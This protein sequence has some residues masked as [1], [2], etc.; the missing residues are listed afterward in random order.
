MIVS[1]PLVACG[2]RVPSKVAWKAVAFPSV[3][4]DEGASLE[5]VSV[6]QRCQI[7]KLR[8]IRALVRAPG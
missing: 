3:N 4:R 5:S 2:R 8:A 7:L 6:A 1:M